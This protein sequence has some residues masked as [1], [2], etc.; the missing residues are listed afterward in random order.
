MV[1]RM[2]K[3]DS[4]V[5]RTVM[6]IGGPN[7]ASPCGVSNVAVTWNVPFDLASTG[8]RKGGLDSVTVITWSPSGKDSLGLVKRTFT[9]SGSGHVVRTEMGI[10]VRRLVMVNWR[11]SIGMMLPVT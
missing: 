7:G 11:R 1:T 10:V 6:A 5:D 8:T 9:M 4:A 2:P 3:P